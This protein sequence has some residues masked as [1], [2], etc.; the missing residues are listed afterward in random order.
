MSETE[1]QLP[2]FPMPRTHPLLPP[3]EYQGL[4]EGKCPIRVQY[5]WGEQ[6]WLLTRYEDVR[7]ALASPKLS[8]DNANPSLPRV[9]P[10]PPGPSTV[11]FTHMDDPDHGRLRRTVTSEFTFRRIE[12]MREKI[13]GVA[14]QLVDEMSAVGSPVDLISS[15]ALPFPSLVMCDILGVPPDDQEFFQARS[16]TVAGKA[17]E[18]EVMQAFAELSQYLDELVT[19]KEKQPTDDLISRVATKYVRNE[20]RISHFELVEMV[21]IL[22]IAGHETTASMIGLS[23]V[24]L[25]QH[26]DQL[27]DMLTDPALLRSAVDELLRMHSITISGVV[28]AA[29]EDLDVGG[30]TIK[31]DDGVAFSLLAANYDERV[32]AEPEK[33]DIRRDAR[34]HLAYGHGVHQCIGRTLANVELEIALGTLFRRLPELKIAVPFEE[35][36]FRPDTRFIYG[37]ET[38][39]VT[40]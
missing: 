29:V 14:D 37:I 23:V 33:F 30:H 21:R 10:M 17:S 11:S 22:L 16:H 4:R 34:H 26:P 1:D 2:P 38:L 39:P 18:E 36:A 31:A 35:I 9:H 28:R 40:W 7:S 25:L 5:P 15:F 6:P 13:Q 20:G 12:A 8:S 27:Q 24:T 19:A 3:P 32:F